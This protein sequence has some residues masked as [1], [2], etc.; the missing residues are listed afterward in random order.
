ME[1]HLATEL[2]FMAWLCENAKID[3]QMEFLEKHL[4]SWLPAFHAD[5]EKFSMTDFY[6]AAGKMTLGFVYMEKEL[7]TA[8]LNGEARLSKSFS[9]RNERF[10]N[11][12]ARLQEH[13]RVYAPMRFPKR[14]PKGRDLIR[15]GE[16]S[17]LEDIVYKE[18][19]HFSPKECFY[20]VSQT[21][22]RFDGDAC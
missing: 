4:V 8:M 16:I 11:I 20:P 18:K 10:A 13:Y 3:E 22:F 15:Y 12:L 1:D 5:L 17:R 2:E 14:G 7:L 19:S 21:L 9:V 6:R